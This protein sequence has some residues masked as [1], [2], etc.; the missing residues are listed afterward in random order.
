MMNQFRFWSIPAVLGA[1]LLAATAVPQLRAT[2][3][4]DDIT[5]VTF[6]APVEIGHI[7]LSAGTY[8]FRTM[9]GNSDRNIVEVMDQNDLHLIAL[10]H[11]VPVLA[12]PD[13]G[14]S[15]IEMS[16]GPANAPERVHAWFV[17]GEWAGWEFPAPGK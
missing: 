13:L 6:S 2:G 7:A 1:A 15:Q 12:P 3:L 16:E 4:N 8:V 14:S 17:P 10:L 9:S 11:S 5:R